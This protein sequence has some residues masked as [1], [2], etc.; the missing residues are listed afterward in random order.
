MPW[1]LANDHNVVTPPAAE[2]GHGVGARKVARV[3]TAATGAH[4]C[5]QV[6]ERA[7]QGFARSGRIV[8]E[9]EDERDR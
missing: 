4:F 3:H 1:R 2:A 8:R 6:G 7:S 9:R 5:V